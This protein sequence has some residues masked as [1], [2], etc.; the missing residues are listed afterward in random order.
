M[1]PRVRW[2]GHV[3]R[4]GGQRGCIGS[5]WGNRREGVQCGDLFVDGFGMWRV[6]LRK[7]VCIGSWWGN[8]REGVQCGDLGVDVFGMWR[9]WVR[10]VWCNVLVGKME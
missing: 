7:G 4:M 3:A 8:R 5:S 1:R 10:K 9:V 6:W 2:A